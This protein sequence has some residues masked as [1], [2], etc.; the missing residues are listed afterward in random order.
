MISDTNPLQHILAHP[1]EFVL[2]NAARHKSLAMFWPYPLYNVT[3]FTIFVKWIFE[4]LPRLFTRR[5][6]G[7]G[8][9]EMNVSSGKC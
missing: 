5:D 6:G 8:K 7:Q 1:R 9:R 3:F 4:R 2:V